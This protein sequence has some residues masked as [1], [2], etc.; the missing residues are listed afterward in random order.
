MRDERSEGSADALSAAGVRKA[1][2]EV[3]ALSGV[4]LTVRPGEI[5]ALLGANGAGKTTLLEILLGLQQADAGTARL[6]GQEPQDA[7][8]SGAVGA[9][10]Q[11]GSLLPD[12]TVGELIRLVCACYP[13]HAPLEQI[14]HEAGVTEFLGRR[15]DVLSGGQAQ[16][17]KLAMALCSDPQ[18]LILDEPTVAMDVSARRE[19]WQ[20]RETASGLGRT[21][22]FATHYLDEAENYAD[23][24][25][26][27][28]G[29][30]VIAD[31]PA[32]A[33]TEVVGTREIRCR[34]SPADRGE[35]ESLPGV[36]EVRISGDHVVLRC[37]D[38]DRALRTLL[39][40]NPGATRI[41]VVGATLE[42]AFIAITEGVR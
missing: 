38:S 11:T 1:F 42:D 36:A 40:R 33:L 26:V 39:D 10:L 27:I 25:V 8:R 20:R 41:E 23:R 14:A 32:D 4:D 13:R 22:L 2:G 17:V 16:R 19:F 21:L 31:A 24:V 18:L 6:L 28:A 35:L 5:V 3:V 12:V 15:T 34:L 9:M 29:G 7:L 30:K 37:T